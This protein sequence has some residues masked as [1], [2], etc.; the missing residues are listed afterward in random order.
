MIR[1][2]AAS[3][4]MR[5][6][7][8][9][10][11]DADNAIIKHE[12]GRTDNA[13]PNNDMDKTKTDAGDKA[14]AQNT[15]SEAHQPDVKEQDMYNP[16]VNPIAA[17]WVRPHKGKEAKPLNPFGAVPRFDTDP[18]MPFAP[19]R[20][21]DLAPFRDELAN[22]VVQVPGRF[23]AAVGQLYPDAELG[24]ALHPA[25][26]NSAQRF[27]GRT[28]ARSVALHFPRLDPHCPRLGNAN[29]RAYV[30]ALRRRDWPTGGVARV[31][32]TE[33]ARAF[34]DELK[35]AFDVLPG[36]AEVWFYVP[37]TLALGSG[38]GVEKGVLVCRGYEGRKGPQPDRVVRDWAVANMA[39]VGQD[40]WAAAVLRLLGEAEVEADRYPK[41]TKAQREAR[42][43]A[44]REREEQH[45]LQAAGRAGEESGSEWAGEDEK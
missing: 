33:E 42:E 27:L 5:A 32:D 14:E 25:S 16:E 34:F 30:V 36:G 43:R 15:G 22:R 24:V 13:F 3:A 21:A 45:W 10:D 38:G 11:I 17:Y 40:R 19:W 23:L 41:P 26:Q 20:A 28:L 2:A 8:E 37:Y 1:D 29:D 6:I 4:N 12:P 18:A 9:Y 39:G 35:G 44:A 7:K 31:P